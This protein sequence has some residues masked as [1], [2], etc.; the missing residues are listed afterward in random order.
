MIGILKRKTEQDMD[1]TERTRREGSQGQRSQEKAAL[2][3]PQPQAPASRAVR[4]H[5]S[6]VYVTLSVVFCYGSPSKLIHYYLSM[7]SSNASPAGKPPLTPK[8]TRLPSLCYH[9][10]WV[11]GL[12]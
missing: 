2:P 1:N 8:L 11:P 9:P 10:F 12:V 6:G 7:S 5:T 3:T 4:K